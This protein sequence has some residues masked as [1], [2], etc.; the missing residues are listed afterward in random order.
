MAVTRTRPAASTLAS[1]QAK[2]VRNRKA[3]L[4]VGVTLGNHTLD[5]RD[6]A[7]L[8]RYTSRHSV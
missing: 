6:M 4:R 7:R 1:E 2:R 3:R 5:S 8:V